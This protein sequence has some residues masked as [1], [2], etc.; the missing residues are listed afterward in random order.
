MVFDMAALMAAAASLFVHAQLSPYLLFALVPLLV[1]VIPLVRSVH[2][3]SLL[4]HVPYDLVYLAAAVAAIVTGKLYV[5]AAALPVKWLLIY[6]ARKW[7]PDRGVFNDMKTRRGNQATA[8][9]A[10]YLEAFRNVYK[11]TDQDVASRRAS[12]RTAEEVM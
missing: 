1:A 6:M 8:F 2:V 3:S 7:G 12:A 10:N 9:F 4:I 5:L 11:S